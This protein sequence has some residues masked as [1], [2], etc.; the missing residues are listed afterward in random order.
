VA[1]C[2]IGRVEAGNAGAPYGQVI[3][4]SGEDAPGT[5]NPQRLR[6]VP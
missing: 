4:P 2:V 1:V 6:I 3:E 5:T